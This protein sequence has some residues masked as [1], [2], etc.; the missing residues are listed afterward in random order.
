MSGVPVDK[1]GKEVAMPSTAPAVEFS[2]ADRT[3]VR[4]EKFSDRIRNSGDV[5][6]IG[7]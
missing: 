6:K 5:E 4:A 7:S 2:S 1:R 3:V